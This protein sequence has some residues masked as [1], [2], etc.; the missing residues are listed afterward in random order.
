[1]S[2]VKLF[3]FYVFPEEKRCWYKIGLQFTQRVINFGPP[4]ELILHDHFMLR[5]LRRFVMLKDGM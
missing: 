5:K 2:N 4:M 3:Y 1:M